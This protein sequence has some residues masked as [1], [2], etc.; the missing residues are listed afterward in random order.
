MRIAI[1][2]DYIGAIGGGEKLV[3]TLARG[4]RAD[5]ITTDIDTES[6]RK[7]RFED[8]RIISIGETV[9]MPPLKQI[10][11]S[12]R[13][14]LCD[15]S[16][17]YDFFIFSGNWAHFAAKRHK[18]NMWYCFTPTRAFYDLYETFMKRQ[19]FITR[20]LFKLWVA[21]H[22]P[23]SR[24][25]VNDVEYVVTISRNVRNRIKKYHGRDSVVVY[26]AVDISKYRPKKYGDFWLSV[27]RLYPEKRVELQ[28]NAFRQMPDE[29]LLIVGGFAKGDHASK[30]ASQV[31][32]N[33]PHNVQLLGSIPEDELIELYATCKGHITTALDEDFGMTPIEA[34]ASG[35]PTIAV[36]EG[37]YLE[38]VVDGS[39]GTL[40]EADETA[41]I[42]AVKLIS[43]NPGKYQKECTV[44]AKDFDTST[45]IKRMVSIIES[46]QRKQ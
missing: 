5:V 6:I 11:A 45:F 38:T 36:K 7:M 13:F 9:K 1:F 16:K 14:A 12:L 15:F 18:P 25:F 39:T 46:L 41:I 35:K 27:N 44:R 28:I 40:I 37:G 29:K 42:N 21:V 34:M 10:S 30:Y 8:V 4:L 31:I 17:D 23:V 33:L 2:H 26:P 20:Q 32:N 24:K 43:K 3:L 22:E 19:S